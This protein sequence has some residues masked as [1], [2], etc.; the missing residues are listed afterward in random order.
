MSRREDLTGRQFGKWRV[1]RFDHTS[2]SRDSFWLCV[3]ECGTFKRVPRGRLMHADVNSG[4]GHDARERAAAKVRVAPNSVAIF[5]GRYVACRSAANRRGIDFDL[6]L[7]DFAQL[8]TQSCRYCGAAPTMLP[9]SRPMVPGDPRVN[10]LDR[11]DNSRGYVGSNV[12][13]CCAICNRMKLTLS[14]S[15]FFDHIRRIAARIGN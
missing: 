4:C 5:N 9:R 10:G 3:C 8:V 14:T 12:V 7:S 11:V 15:E 1:L 13:A 6:S 2:K